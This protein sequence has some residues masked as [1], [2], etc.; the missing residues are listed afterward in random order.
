MKTSEL[1]K[2]DGEIGRS[3]HSMNA[4]AV[5][6]S[7]LTVENSS[8]PDGLEISWSPSNL[9]VSKRT[10][11]SYAQKSSIVFSVEAFFDY[12]ETI[13]KNSL[14][15][16]PN[17]NFQGELKKAEKVS[18]FLGQIRTIPTEVRILAELACHWR[19]RIVHL[20]SN[21]CLSS[22]KTDSLLESRDH[23]Y[24]NYHHFDVVI[25]LENFEHQ[26]MT[27]KD[28]TTLTTML[29]KSAHYV[30]A[31]F[32]SELNDEA[33]IP[34]IVEYLIQLSP[35]QIILGQDE[36]KKR[37]RQIQRFIQTNL[38]FIQSEIMDKL[39]PSLK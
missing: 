8:V 13:S 37:T 14:W 5:A 9:D 34:S 6:L 20:G 28:S 15:P 2:F 33:R 36:S 23:I 16:N 18:N 7:K 10:S 21:A 35:F 30:D 25:A 29:L 19:N 17:I 39:M 38:P 3:V 1:K 24:D 32:I 22:S 12:L 26:K 27:L 31:Y 11:R 4:I